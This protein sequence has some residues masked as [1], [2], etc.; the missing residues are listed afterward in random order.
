MVAVV[1]VTPF[2]PTF[3]AVQPEEKL[4]PWEDV[5]GALK[6][7]QRRSASWPARLGIVGIV[8]IGVV[9]GMWLGPRVGVDLSGLSTLPAEL[10]FVHSDAPHPAIGYVTSLADNERRES[11]CEST[12]CVTSQ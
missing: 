4:R 9:T 11:E 10:G 6:L 1:A 5:Q 3:T 8:L 7:R 12:A 2:G